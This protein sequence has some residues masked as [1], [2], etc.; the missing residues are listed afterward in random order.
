M[1]I[2]TVGKSDLKVGVTVRMGG[3]GGAGGEGSWVRVT[4]SQ[5]GKI[6][7][8]DTGSVGILA[9]SIGGGGGSGGN[10]QQHDANSFNDIVGSPTSFASAAAKVASW[11]A[12]APQKYRT[13][14]H[15]TR[16]STRRWQSLTVAMAA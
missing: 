5:I 1:K 7:T 12:T 16:S 15:G 13:S 10:I 6:T 3:N 2:P 8:T 11:I 4:N 9:Q 14:R